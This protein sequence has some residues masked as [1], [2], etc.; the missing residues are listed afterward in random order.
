[1]RWPFVASVGPADIQ[2]THMQLPDLE[3]EESSKGSN[4]DTSEIAVKHSPV[5]DAGNEIKQN[6]EPTADSL[7]VRSDDMP[8]L[9]LPA[10]LGECKKIP[11]DGQ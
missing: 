8:A 4:M 7:S 2:A 5:D 10:V 11:I 3:A 9:A 6:A 1:M